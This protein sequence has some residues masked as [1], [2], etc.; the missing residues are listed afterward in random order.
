MRISQ[1]EVVFNIEYKGLQYNYNKTQQ[2]L[3]FNDNE[4]GST[5]L[6]ETL[7]E[8]PGKLEGLRENFKNAE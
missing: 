5:F 8:L 6:I 7:L 2:Y 4:T 3:C 1:A